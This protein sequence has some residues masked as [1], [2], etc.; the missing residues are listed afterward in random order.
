MELFNYHV[1]FDY[2]ADLNEKKFKSLSILLVY[3]TFSFQ[4]IRKKRHFSK[5]KR[6]SHR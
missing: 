2:F 6:G 4:V 1:K 3:K 5:Y